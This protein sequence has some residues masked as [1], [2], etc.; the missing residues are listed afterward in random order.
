MRMVLNEFITGG[1]KQII[2]LGGGYDTNYFNLNVRPFGTSLSSC[3]P[4]FYL[5][6]G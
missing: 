1:G 6:L 3:I 2:S 4:K 5:Y